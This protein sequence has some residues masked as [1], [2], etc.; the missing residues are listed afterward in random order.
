MDGLKLTRPDVRFRRRS[1]DEDGEK[2]SGMLVGQKRFLFFVINYT[3]YEGSTDM[4]IGPRISKLFS[5]I[6]DIVFFC[7]DPVPGYFVVKNEKLE[8]ST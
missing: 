7:F 3:W 4:R 6:R 8:S 5:V 1:T 2:D